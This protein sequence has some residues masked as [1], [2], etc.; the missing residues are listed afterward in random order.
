MESASLHASSHP[1][2]AV[3]PTVSS[4]DCVRQCAGCVRRWF[5]LPTWWTNTQRQKLSPELS[6]FHVRETSCTLKHNSVRTKQLS[7]GC[8]SPQIDLNR[9]EE[10]EYM[11]EELIGQLPKHISRFILNVFELPTPRRVL[12]LGRLPFGPPGKRFSWAGTERNQRHRRRHFAFHPLG[13]SK[14]RTSCS[15]TVGGQHCQALWVKALTSCGAWTRPTGQ[16]IERSVP[17]FNN[18]TVPRGQVRDMGT[19]PLDKSDTSCSTISFNEEWLNSRR[20]SSSCLGSVKDCLLT[21]RTTSVHSFRLIL[22]GTS[23]AILDMALLLQ[24]KRKGGSTRRAPQRKT[25]Y[26]LEKLLCLR[27]AKTAGIFCSSNFI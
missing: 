22:V 9:R 10:M 12:V 14:T 17:P 26:M 27:P 20:I 5:A 25:S 19:V 13:P 21:R 16:R 15:R 8:R 23:V 24:E 6:S 3:G 4:V 11:H 18:S 2:L 1:L 7:V